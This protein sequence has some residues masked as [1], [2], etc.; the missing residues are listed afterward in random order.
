MTLEGVSATLQIP[1][2]AR[3]LETGRDD[4]VFRDPR[5]VELGDAIGL[6]LAAYGKAWTQM[7][8]VVG[9]TVLVDE[10][11]GDFLTRH[12]D[13]QVVELGAGLCT[14]AWRLPLGRWVHV[15]LP[16]VAELRRR[17]LP[18]E[19]DRLT[20]A[21]DVL[22]DGWWEQ[23]EDRPTLFVAEGLL[24]YLDEADVQRLLATCAER[25]PGSEVVLEGIAS[26]LLRSRF[27]QRSETI[28]ATGAVFRWGLDDPGQLLEL[29]P[30]A[31]IRSVG[32][33]AEVLPE[34]WRWL[35][36][37]RPFKRVRQAMRVVHLELP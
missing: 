20:V 2:A 8:A 15:D 22:D 5:G 35:R 28:A 27:G 4:G 16:A 33:H 21:A 23:V 13:G 7:E 18:D 29:V 30:G 12:P 25:A 24:M 10:V 31:R 6:D 11:V 34:R 1:L 36:V 37:T 19:P 3:V 26:F 32:H 17:L 14:R 9:R